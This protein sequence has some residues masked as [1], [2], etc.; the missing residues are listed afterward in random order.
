VRAKHPIDP[1]F[2][3]VGKIDDPD[4]LPYARSSYEE[5]LA[6]LERL[7]ERFHEIPKLREPPPATES[8]RWPTIREILHAFAAH[9]VEFVIVGGYAVVF[10]GYDRFTGDIDLFIHP[11]PENAGSIIRAFESLGFT[12]SDLT[13]E[14]LT[15]AGS[16]FRFGN[17]PE[18]TELLLQVKGTTWD[19]AWRS[20]IE[21]PLMGVSVRFL[22]LESLI[23]TKAAAGRPG[24][25]E[26]IERLRQIQRDS[27]LKNGS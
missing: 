5:R 1:S 27:W 13:V 19:E 11:T 22:D 23:N 7:R 2:L 8:R 16:V 21:R 26:D 15:H 24:D 17:R 14:G 3:S 9:N 20:A 4:P 10:H 18:Q 12:H 6:A 25:I